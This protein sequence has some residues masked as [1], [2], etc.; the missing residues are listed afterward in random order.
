M[1]VWV[2]F[3]RV[4][5]LASVALA[6]RRRVETCGE[7][8]KKGEEGCASWGWQRPAKVQVTTTTALTKPPC[9]CLVIGT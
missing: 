5:L 8:E 9:L 4:L 6:V 3:A 7:R 1:C 2:A